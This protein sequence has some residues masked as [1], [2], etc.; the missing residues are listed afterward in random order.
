MEDGFSV[1]ELYGQRVGFL[2]T[3]TI[4]SEAAKD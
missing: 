2:G 1:S 3:G 4:S